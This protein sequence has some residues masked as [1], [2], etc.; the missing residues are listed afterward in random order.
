MSTPHDIA[1]QYRTQAQKDEENEIL[2]ALVLVMSEQAGAMRV[3]AVSSQRAQ[4]A[5]WWFSFASAA[6]A[7]GS[8]TVA[9]LALTIG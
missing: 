5:A 8:L 6:I 2:S 4:R 9:V 1:H 7:A 3:Q